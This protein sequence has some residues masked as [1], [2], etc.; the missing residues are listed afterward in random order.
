MEGLILL[1]EEDCDS[2]LNVSEISKVTTSLAPNPVTEQSVLTINNFQNSATI[3]FYNLLGQY[4]DQK[5]ILS[6]TT[7]I[8]H[9]DFPASGIYFYQLQQE[10]KIISTQKL[11]VR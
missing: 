2:L 11:I 5:E 1:N 4:I 6:N 7:T 8:N 9:S 10:G 3:T